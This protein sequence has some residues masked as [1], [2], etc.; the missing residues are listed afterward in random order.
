MSTKPREHAITPDDFMGTWDVTRKVI[1]H[2][3]G[4]TYLFEG[5]AVL[6]RELFEEAGD[7]RVG[8]G[9][10]QSS[11]LYRIEIG[12]ETVAI[13]RADGSDFVTLDLMSSQAVQHLCG[14]DMYRGRFFFL[15]GDSWAETWRVR[16]PHKS[17]VSLTRY[18][19]SK[20]PQ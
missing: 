14:E 6:T 7:T 3:T 17:Y 11:R 20:N 2:R 19:R 12:R 13:R 16:G 10:F 9:R 18:R 8:D 5:R 15:D 1:D 4:D